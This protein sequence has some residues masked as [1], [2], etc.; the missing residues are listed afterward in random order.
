M[1]QENKTINNNLSNNLNL[2]DKNMKYVLHI[3]EF[4]SKKSKEITDH[5]FVPEIQ[6]LC[7]LTNCK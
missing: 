1:Q 4:V 3:K 5:T 2:K 7:Q 6:E